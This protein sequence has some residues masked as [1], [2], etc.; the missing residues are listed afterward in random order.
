MELIGCPE[1]SATIYLPMYAVNIPEEQIPHL[2]RGGT[3][4][5]LTKP[6][7]TEVTLNIATDG[8]VTV[9]PLY[10]VDWFKVCVMLLEQSTREEGVER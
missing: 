2:H 10:V 4:K 7:L 5:S 9:T 8:S 1:T 6:I 3:L